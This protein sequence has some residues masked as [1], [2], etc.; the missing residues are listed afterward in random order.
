MV[1][2]ESMYYQVTE[3]DNQQVFLKILW[4]DSNK[5]HK[6]LQDFAMFA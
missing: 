6:E 1:D 4:W 2:V 5:L 3:S